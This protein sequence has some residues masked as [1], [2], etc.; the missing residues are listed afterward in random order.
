MTPMLPPTVLSSLSKFVELQMGL[1]FPQERWVDL[2]RGVAATASDLGFWDVASYARWLLS[3]PMARHQI[4]RLA[5]HLTVGETYFFREKN[6]FDALEQRILPDLIDTCNN[7]GRHLRVWS[8]GCCTGEEPYSIAMLLDRLQPQCP[9]TILATDINP[10]F[11]RKAADGVYGE[12]SFRETPAW[13]R[14][15]YFK[16]GR[17]AR[18]EINPAIRKQ[19]EFTYLNLADD[20]Y[21]SLTNNTNAMDIIFCRNVLMYFTAE[22]VKK[23][24]DGFYRSLVDGGWLIVSPAETSNALFARFNAV[25]FPGAVL[26]RKSASTKRKTA[27]AGYSALTWGL[28]PEPS[29]VLESAICEA[30]VTDNSGIADQ[31]AMLPTHDP[32]PAEEP[33]KTASVMARVCADQGKLAEAAD[34]CEQAINADKLNPAHHYLYATIQQELGQSAAAMRSLVHALYLAPDFILAHFTLG[35]LCLSQGQSREAERHFNNAQSLLK[36]Y[37]QD[38]VLPESDGLTAGRLGEIIASIRLSLPHAAIRG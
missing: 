17:N 36:T 19:V 29:L 4:E 35:N 5:N 1:H 9:T 10:Q 11:L 12:W 24:V 20:V 21:P 13:I 26:Y 2:E 8:A 37:P 34:W 31:S 15:R 30:P 27:T 38:G 28:E 6:S 32:A 7:A 18:F 22:R 14:D 3:A 23:I 25:E 16:Q 33:C